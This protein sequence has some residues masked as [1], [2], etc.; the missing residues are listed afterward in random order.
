MVADQMADGKTISSPTIIE[1]AA[2]ENFIDAHKNI[3]AYF[4]GNDHINRVYEWVGPNKKATL[5]TVGSDSPMKGS[6]SAKDETKLAFDLISIDTKNM[7]LTVRSAYWNAD[8]SN[9][10]APIVWNAPTT[11]SLLPR[12]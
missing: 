10:D 7:M 11:F 3:V 6:V 2:L 5:H 4:H 8:P 9:A 1:Q 12:K